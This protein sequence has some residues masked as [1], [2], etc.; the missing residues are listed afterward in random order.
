FLAASLA[1]FALSVAPY[2]ASQ[3][4]FGGFIAAGA[5]TGVGLLLLVSRAPWPSHLALATLAISWALPT[6][7]CFLPGNPLAGGVTWVQLAFAGLGVAAW[8]LGRR[9]IEKELKP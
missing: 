5:A 6:T 3:I 4:A 1:P 9:Q 8:V 2:L 7:L